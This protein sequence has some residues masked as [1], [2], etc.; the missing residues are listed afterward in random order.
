MGKRLSGEVSKIVLSLGEKEE[1]LI[2]EAMRFYFVEKLEATEAEQ[3]NGNVICV[4]K[5]SFS[6]TTK[7]T[8]GAFCQTD[9]IEEHRQGPT[10]L[11]HTV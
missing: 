7:R 4:E 1:N 8:G 3:Q 9:K 5:K 2:I 6:P 11:E 10:F